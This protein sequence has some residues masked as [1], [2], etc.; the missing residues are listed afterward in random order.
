MLRSK[1]TILRRH[2]LTFPFGWR[3]VKSAFMVKK[4]TVLLA[5]TDAHHGF[6]QGVARYAREHR[7][8]LVADMIYTA[9]I[10]LGWRGDGIISF[11]GYRDDLA[12][13][14]LKSRLPTVELSMVRSDIDLPRVEGDNEMIGKLAAEHFLER[15]FRHFVWAPLIDDIVNAERYRGFANHLAKQKLSCHVLPTADTRAATDGRHDWA[16]RRRALIRELRRLPKPLA[17]FGY[18]DC[19][20]AD[21]IDACDQANLLVPEAV[22]VL[23][24]DNDTMLCDCISVPL[25]SVCH[26]LQGMAYE[27][28]ALLDRLMNGRKAPAGVLRVPPKGLVTRRSTDILAVNNLQV[29]RAL[30]FIRDRYTDRLLGV[31]EVVTATAIS[32]RQLELAFRRE[33]RRTINEDIVSVRLNQVKRLLRTTNQ[34]VSAISAATGFSRP[35]H[36]FRTFRKHVAMSP[37]TYRSRRPPGEPPP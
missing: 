1:D 10:P 26:D 32:R 30:R 18:N 4:R 22:A 24:V 23:G 2:L 31:D 13:F 27:A 34:T 25:S 9:K 16:A 8:H 36:L 37:K 7:W 12:D 29:S 19:V 35:A 28:A 17:V 33:M 20:A 15:G 3:P 6:F 21:I 14:I 5:L 11:I